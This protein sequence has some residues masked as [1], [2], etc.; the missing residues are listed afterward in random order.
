LGVSAELSLPVPLCFWSDEL[1]PLLQLL[2]FELLRAPPL[3]V[4]LLL[5]TTELL[6]PPLQ[7]TL[8][9]FE[10]LEFEPELELEPEFEQKTAD[11][12]L[13]E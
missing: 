8:L 10:L 7:L 1:P 5:Q 6:L 2:L 11:S 4:P 13:C 3:L 9:L 12:A